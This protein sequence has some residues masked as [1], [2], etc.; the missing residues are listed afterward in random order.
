MK[1]VQQ[2][3]KGD[4]LMGLCPKELLFFFEVTI[5]TLPYSK[6]DGVVPVRSSIKSALGWFRAL[7]ISRVYPVRAFSCKLSDNSEKICPLKIIL[8]L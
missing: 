6:C 7:Y 1:A 4:F 5:Q 8:V 3:K 2:D